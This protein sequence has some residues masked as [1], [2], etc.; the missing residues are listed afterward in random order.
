MRTCMNVR[1]V[2]T[3]SG[4][5]HHYEGRRLDSNH[6]LFSEPSPMIHIPPC[7]LSSYIRGFLVREGYY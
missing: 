4:A 3:K 2:L 1:V 5:S 7:I 6:P